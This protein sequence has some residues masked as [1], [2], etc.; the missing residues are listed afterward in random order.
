MTEEECQAFVREL[1]DEMRPLYKELEATAAATLRVRPVFL[2]KQPFP[3]RCEMI[4][5]AMALKVNA[6]EAGEILAGFLMERYADDVKALLDGLGL[7]HDEGVLEE[8]APAQPDEKAL[9]KILKEFRA[10]ENALM[11]EVL[12]KAFAAQAAIDWP[13]LDDMLF[14]QLETTGGTK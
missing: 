10:G 11:R 13:L 14:P 6:E 3:K 1:R 12:L 5:K 8:T 2:G 9:K 4:R 7:K